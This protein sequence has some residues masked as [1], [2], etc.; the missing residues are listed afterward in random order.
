MTTPHP[1]PEERYDEA[2][3]RSHGAFLNRR[4]PGSPSREDY[5]RDEILIAIREAEAAG[6]ARGRAMEQQEL[7]TEAMRLRGKHCTPV[8]T[9]HEEG[10]W[11]H[12]QRIE[13]MIRDHTNKDS[14]DV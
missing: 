12:G 13:A 8:G 7:L 11:D 10:G 6:E 4:R 2:K 9:Q 3:S 5:F 14:S 1:T